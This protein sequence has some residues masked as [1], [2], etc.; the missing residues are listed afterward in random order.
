MGQRLGRLSDRLLD[1]V[2]PKGRAAACAEACWT[3]RKC[4]SYHLRCRTCCTCAGQTYCDAWVLCCRGC[5]Y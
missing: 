4:F 2:V 1:A 5:C 3:E